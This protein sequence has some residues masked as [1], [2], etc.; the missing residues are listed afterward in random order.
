MTER[1]REILSW[2]ESDN[3]GT[4]TNLARVLDHG[5]LGGSGKLVILPVDQGVEHGP[6]RSF[7]TNP[8]A[9]DPRYHFELA[10]EAGCNAY[11]A[12]LGFLEAGARQFAG[13][14]PLILKMN[15]HDVLLEE[16]DP[17]QAITGSVRDARRLGCVAVGFTIYPGSTHR[18]EMYGQIREIAEEA[19]QEGLAVVIWSYPRGSGLSKEGE[20]AV[21]V[22]AY[23][24]H[25]AAQLGAHIIKVKLP[26]A[27]LEQ[28]PAKK[29]YETESIPIGTL[30]ERVRHVVQAA[31]N[32]RRI[33]IFSGGAANKDEAVF[34]EVRAIRDG[35]GFGSIIGRNSFQRKKPD[36]LKFLKT[37]MDIYA[38][39]KK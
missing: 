30:A 31:F 7:G 21:D 17:F 38:G 5:T 20:T 6:A 2:Y 32:G 22:T 28:A 4:L 8:P 29:V 36:A 34:D 33:V 14:V 26:S 35:G 12:P 13:Q 3:P 25:I 1:V 37:V 23:A 39:T 18:L 15:N 16:R 10:I 24:A 19:K 11:A 9:Y 27:H